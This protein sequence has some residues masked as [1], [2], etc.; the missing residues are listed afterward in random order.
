MVD[1]QIRRR[2][3]YAMLLPGPKTPLNSRLIC[4]D[5]KYSPCTTHA[6]GE[7]FDEYYIGHNTIS[8]IRK[9]RIWTLNMDNVTKKRLFH[10]RILTSQQTCMGCLSAWNWIPCILKMYF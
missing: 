5:C 9:N 3:Q 10:R 7:K 2:P 1:G 4:D 8:S 6:G